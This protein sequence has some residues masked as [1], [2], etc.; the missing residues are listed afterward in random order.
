MKFKKCVKI[1]YTSVALL[2]VALILNG[3]WN[4]RELDSIS[5]LMGIGLDK[6]DREGQIEMTSQLAALQ[7][8][9]QSG[10]QGGG[11]KF[12]NVS[13]TGQN[14]FQILRGDTHV[15]NNKIYL[16]HNQVVIF[17]EDLAKEGLDKYMD[18][19]MHDH[20]ARLNAWV[21]IAKGRASDVLNIEDKLNSI[22]ALG[23]S[24]LMKD[25]ANNSE[26]VQTK[27][28]DFYDKLVTQSTAPIVPIV[29]VRGMG[30]DQA[31]WVTGAAVFVR[32]K[33]VGELDASETQGLLW[34]NGKIISGVIPIV[35]TGG[36]A[37]IEIMHGKS[38]TNVE[39][40]DGTI[41]Y[42]VDIT[43]EFVLGS[44]SG[45]L[46]LTDQNFT[47]EAEKNISEAVKK[48]INTVYQKT[49]R[50][51]ADIFG[52]G[53]S[54]YRKYPSDWE[55]GL[56]QNWDQELQKVVFQVNVKSTLKGT[57]RSIKAI[58]LARE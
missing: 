43:G 33:M 45:D 16:P 58:D 34:V 36:D 19:F 7:P 13:V 26:T 21:L 39:L 4:S 32:D 6:T 24:D 20:E 28:L 12:W 46:D 53:D 52:I 57:G 27:I 47:K 8:S 35:V 30:A 38:T 50:M 51:G 41:Y 54:I 15:V 55:N 25:Q 42:N 37:E 14:V 31:I 22:P 56:K 40:K 9:T 1:F 5:I 10:S 2:M 23:L 44:C 18:F 48:Q 17:G 29:E 11:S 49:I 3:C